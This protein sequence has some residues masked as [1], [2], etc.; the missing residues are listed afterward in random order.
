MPIEDRYCHLLKIHE[1]VLMLDVQFLRTALKELFLLLRDQPGLLGP[2]ILFVWMALSM[3]RDE[4]LWL[5]RHI[6]AWPLVNTHKKSREA[7]NSVVIDKHLPELLF[8]VN[9]L[10]LLVQR[11]QQIIS[12]YHIEYVAS[13]D[14]P[15]LEEMLQNMDLR[16]LNENDQLLITSFLQSISNTRG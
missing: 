9:E 4:V 15:L 10:R 7:L 1:R 11:H 5:L 16:Q 13:Y 3:A 14:A 8:Y 2:K 12:A 6:D